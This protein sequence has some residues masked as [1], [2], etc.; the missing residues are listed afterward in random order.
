MRFMLDT[1]IC[2]ELLRGAAGRVASRMQRHDIDEIAISSIALAELQYG[3][4]RSAR[5]AHHETLLIEFCAPL[6]ILPFDDQAALMYGRVRADLQRAGT[7]IGPLDTLI[8]A[9]AQ[10]LDL[11]LVTDNEREFARVKDLRVEKWTRA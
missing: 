6:A 2:I 3:V 5:P 10:A 4:A 11:T 8:A 7:Q 1:S 9:H